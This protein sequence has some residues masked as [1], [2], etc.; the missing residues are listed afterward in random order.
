MARKVQHSLLRKAKTNKNDEFY[1]QLSDIESELQHYKKHF[2][3]KV[4]FCNCDDARISNFFNYFALNF[5]EL[6]IKKLISACY[7]KQ[8]RDLFNTEEFKSGFFYEYTGAKG[9]KIKP[10]ANDIIYFKGDGGFHSAESIELLKQSDIVVTN[11]PF[12]LF[13]EYVDQLA[14]YDK[15]FLIIG[16]INAI[17]YKE[18]FKLI[19]ENN[20]WLGINLGRGISGFIVPEHYELYGTETGIDGSGNRII[21]P[22]NCLWLTNLDT[23]KRHEDIALTKRYFE[24]EIEYPRYDNYDGINVNK[25]TD[26]PLDYKG[27]MGVPITFLH[28]FNPEQFEIIKFRKGNDE[29]DLSINGKCPYFRI[30]IRNK[31]IQTKLS[32]NRGMPVDNNSYEAYSVGNIEGNLN[33]V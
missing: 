30:L 3:G 16:N 20:A 6:G 17:T 4:V 2:K 31:R 32:D 7:K 5:K 33:N 28:K 1:T 27:F 15:N 26:I 10:D 25:T 13:R 9:E 21:S 8:E 29:K 12:S 19:K 24:N 18:I 11:P 14:K 22:N 23:S